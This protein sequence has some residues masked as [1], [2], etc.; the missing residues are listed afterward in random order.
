MPARWKPRARGR[1]DGALGGQF[2]DF[3]TA[4]ACHNGAAF[5]QFDG[6]IDGFGGDQRVATKTIVSA[7]V[8]GGASDEDG[9]AL[10]EQAGAERVKPAFPGHRLLWGAAIAFGKPV[11]E[12]EL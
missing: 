2:A 10:V 4:A 12:N 7:S 9:F 1:G 11:D 8:A 3:N 5:S 6:R